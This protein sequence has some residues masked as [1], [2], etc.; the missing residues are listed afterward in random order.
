MDSESYNTDGSVKQPT[1]SI[2]NVF[3]GLFSRDRSASAD[4]ESAVLKSFKELPDG[5]NPLPEGCQA[6]NGEN[7]QGKED[8]HQD[9][10]TAPCGTGQ[11]DESLETCKE[12]GNQDEKAAGNL[13]EPD[14]VQVTRVETHSDTE[15][16]DEE[17]S[18]SSSS[19]SQWLPRTREP[20][21]PEADVNKVDNG[22]ELKVASGAEAEYHVP[23]FRTHRL[24]EESIIEAIL[25]SE[26]FKNRTDSRPVLL[27]PVSKQVDD[28]YPK[29]SNTTM[30]ADEE[31]SCATR[32][33]CSNVGTAEGDEYSGIDCSVPVPSI[34][35]GHVTLEAAGHNAAMASPVKRTEAED[36]DSTQKEGTKEGTKE[37]LDSQ[38]SSSSSPKTLEAS[39]QS[40]C[41]PDEQSDSSGI[42][43]Q[44]TSLSSAPEESTRDI[45]PSTS[46]ASQCT[47][48]PKTPETNTPHSASS[49]APSPTSSSS[50]PS[51]GAT[52]PSP[53]SFQMPALFSGL[54]VLKKG[55][56]GEDRD[57]MSEIK[58][59]EKDADLALL[60]LK[61][62]VNKAKLFP[63]QK[64]A[65]SAKKHEELKPVSE[66]KS[67]VMGQ[68]SQP[69]NLDNHV[70]TKKTDEGKD[71][72]PESKKESKN[73][74]EAGGEKSPGPETPTCT[75]ERK[76][77]SDLAYETFRNI[78]GPKSVKKE[79]TENVD[80]E[81]VKKKIKND[82]ENLRSIFV[83]VSK[84]PS[85]ELKSPTEANV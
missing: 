57:T 9:N 23:V 22:D 35:S 48:A 83:R 42:R 52:L 34:I 28:S 31:A 29:E 61:K 84:T 67:T 41:I 62:S 16:A 6:S 46:P 45:Q 54:R 66:S 73:G 1:S 7:K 15:N 55:A 75:P 82:K 40:S 13:I 63:E 14:L 56:V 32:N 44:S 36:L 47:A 76:K 2:R 3:S 17:A 80:L 50:S 78:F 20:T 64:T 59:S 69:L 12:S 5:E 25:Y 51:V 33:G 4:E 10:V 18:H 8:E 79:R 43:N 85:K 30:S 19:L 72:D 21:L 68:L 77:T 26:R 65:T 38:V 37:P 58:Q 70:V 53:P 49:A 39:V 60:S 81:A 71:G 27:S 11:R 24:K 74:E